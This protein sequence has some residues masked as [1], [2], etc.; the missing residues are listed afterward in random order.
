MKLLGSGEQQAVIFSDS[1]ISWPK[2]L[3]F[4]NGSQTLLQFLA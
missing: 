1:S 4:E 2:R 3:I